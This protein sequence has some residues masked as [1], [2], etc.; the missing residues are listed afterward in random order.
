MSLAAGTRLGPYEIGAPI[1]KG[2][3]GEVYRARDTKLGRDVAVKVLPEPFAE[4]EERMARFQR[5]ARVLASLNHPNIAAV[6]GLEESERV[7]FLVMELVPGESLAGKILNG[8]LSVDEATRIV[9]QLIDGLEAAHESGVVHRDLKPANAQITPDGNVKILDFGLAKVES[10]AAEATDISLSPTMTRD[11]T[12]AGM[13]LGTAPYMSPEQARGLPVDKRSDIFSFGCVV[14]EMLTGQKAFR[15]DLVSDVMAAVIKSE[16]DWSLLPRPAENFKPLLQAC[17]EKEPKRRL[18]DIGDARLE[19]ERAIHPPSVDAAPSRV[20]A[21]LAGALAAF[22]VAVGAGVVGWMTRGAPSESRGVLRFQIDAATVLPMLDLSPDGGTLVQSIA[23][24]GELYVRRLDKWE[25]KRVR[26]VEELRPV[27]PFFSP[28]SAWVGFIAPGDGIYRIEVDGGT[29]VRVSDL[30]DDHMDAVWAENGKILIGAVGGIWEVEAFGGEL[31]QVLTLSNDEGARRLAVL[32]GGDAV[33]FQD[34]SERGEAIAIGDLRSGEVEVLIVGGAHP[35]YLD[36]GYL[37]YVSGTSLMAIGFDLDARA[38][39]GHAVPVIDHMATRPTGAFQFASTY[40]RFAVSKKGTLAYVPT[41]PETSQASVVFV[42]PDVDA[43]WRVTE[44]DSAPVSG[45]LRVSPDGKRLAFRGDYG[46]QDVWAHD[47]ERGTLTRLSVAPGEDET[48]VWSPDGRFLMYAAASHDG[49]R[50]NRVPADGSATPETVANLG[51]NHYHIADW[52]RDGK[53]LLFDSSGDIFSLDLDGPAS[54]QPLIHSRFRELMPR[55]S[56][57][58]KSIA[59][60]S[61]ESGR[62]EVYVQRFPELGEKRPISTGGGTEPIWSRDGRRLFYRSDTHVMRVRVLADG[63]GDFAAAEPLFEDTFRRG[64]AFRHAPGS[65][66]VMP[67]GRFV[68]LKRDPDTASSEV[69][70]VVNWVEELEA[71]MVR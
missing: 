25:T 20:A 49:N 48:P 53:W 47:F 51:G 54:P 6:Y 16:P 23:V 15:G 24:P 62:D 50:I 31:R 59:Y 38:T 33:L 40:G 13:I 32:P 17:L 39:V 64:E 35:A 27:F 30:P 8:P 60:V 19:L 12:Q 68:M 22:A 5:E 9:H 42:E 18:R 41:A 7:H 61:D 44:V 4:D 28:D 45:Q 58:G 14:F 26:G 56:P 63:T 34:V 43:R 2:G 57:D 3:M 69:R 66:D 65:Y 29:P 36:G 11:A 52:S 10:G 71:R 21:R 46:E 1:G 55:I 67:D 70:I 37:V